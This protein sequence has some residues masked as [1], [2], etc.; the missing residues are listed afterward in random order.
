[1]SR[2]GNKPS[3]LLELYLSSYG[4]LLISE[5]KLVSYF[6]LLYVN[7]NQQN[8]DLAEY[9]RLRMRYSDKFINFFIDF[10]R[11]ITSQ[12][13]HILPFRTI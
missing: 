7:S 5:Y 8:D 1:M 10:W 3:K 2:I 13:F 12:G 9:E 4:E 11:L 6:N